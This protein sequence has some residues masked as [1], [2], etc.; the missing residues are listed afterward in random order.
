MLDAISWKEHF[1]Y[2][3]LALYLSSLH[4]NWDRDI[5]ELGKGHHMVDM[6]ASWRVF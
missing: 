4:G 3:G 2:W 5:T 6:P 1:H